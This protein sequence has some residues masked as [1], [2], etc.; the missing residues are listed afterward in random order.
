MKSVIGGYLMKSVERVVRIHCENIAGNMVNPCVWDTCRS[1]IDFDIVDPVWSGNI[2]R[3]RRFLD[4]GIRV[5][6]DG[7][8]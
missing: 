6:I 1:C 7:E 2:L 8:L 5:S 3:I 4:A